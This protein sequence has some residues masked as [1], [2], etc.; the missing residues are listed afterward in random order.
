ML[1]IFTVV[2]SLSTFVF[3]PL[4]ASLLAGTVLLGGLYFAYGRGN[5]RQNIEKLEIFRLFVLPPAIVMGAVYWVLS[6]RS[7]GP[8]DV[9]TPLAVDVPITPLAEAAAEVPSTPILTEPFE[10]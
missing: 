4:G 5:A 2:M 10:R 9:A 1:C 7:S 8:V 6:S 3:S